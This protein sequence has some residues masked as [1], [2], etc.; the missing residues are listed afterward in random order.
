M[1]SNNNNIRA[2]ARDPGTIF[3]SWDKSMHPESYRSW[4]LIA[5][6]LT[7][8][9]KIAAELDPGAGKHYLHSLTPDTSYSLKIMASP[10]NGISFMVVDYGILHTL[11]NRISSQADSDPK[12]KTDLESLL[13]LTNTD[14]LGA[15]NKVKVN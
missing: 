7:S 8:G 12:W 13:R 10:L 2:I 11:K 5:E 3:I 4:K 6:D 14:Y 15:S 9:Q 1:K